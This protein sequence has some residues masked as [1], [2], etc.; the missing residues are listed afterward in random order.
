LTHHHILVVDDDPH[1]RAML[2]TALKSFGFAVTLASGGTEAIQTY[3]QGRGAIDLVLL[4]VRMPGLD[5]PETL[6]ALRKADPAVRC[7][8][9]SG[10]A[11]MYSEAELLGMGAAGVIGKPFGKLDALA[12]RLR[13]A[14][15]PPSGRP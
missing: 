13:D 12:D 9:M 11:A 14:A 5:G 8:F 15:G 1:V 10:H 6:A 3:Q 2:G 4:D 7:C